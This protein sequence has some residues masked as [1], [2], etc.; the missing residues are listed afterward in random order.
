[1]LRASSLDSALV[2]SARSRVSSCSLTKSFGAADQRGILHSPA[3][4][5]WSQ[6][7]LMWLDLHV[8]KIGQG[9]GPHGCEGLFS[10]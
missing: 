2:I 4:V 10:H 8:T 3:L 7:A 6:A 5:S 9:P 1:L